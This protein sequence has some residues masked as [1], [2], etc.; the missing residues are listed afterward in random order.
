MRQL[1]LTEP[2]LLGEVIAGAERALSRKV[3]ETFHEPLR[4]HDDLCKECR[5]GTE[6]KG[7]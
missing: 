7:N 2:A 3:I 1:H 5:K 6:P 4:A